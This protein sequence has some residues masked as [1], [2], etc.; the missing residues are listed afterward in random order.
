MRIIVGLAVLLLLIIGVSIF[1]DTRDYYSNDKVALEDINLSDTNSRLGLQTY[2]NLNEDT[3]SDNTNSDENIT[4]V[5]L[6]KDDID[7]SDKSV[8]ETG[9]NM[10]E[11]IQEELDKLDANNTKDYH[12]TTL[13]VKDDNS[14][15]SV[16]TEVNL[17]TDTVIVNKEEKNTTISE[18]NNTISKIKSTNDIDL[19]PFP[20]V[21]NDKSIDVVKDNETISI[22][23]NNESNN[24]T[25]ITNTIK[26]K[27]NSLVIWFKDI[28]PFGKDSEVDTNNSIETTDDINNTITIEKKINDNLSEDINNTDTVDD[29]VTKCV[30]DKC[31]STRTD[32]E[33]TNKVVTKTITKPKDKKVTNK[34]RDYIDIISDPKNKLIIDDILSR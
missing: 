32:K 10:D 3:N 12:V 11:L 33:P 34:K 8:E 2:D 20:M 7:D 22:S 4:P 29:E 23:D 16:T 13:V 28:L 25:S 17:S 21:E 1:K 26:D 15:E 24:S 30:G 5:T 18:V 27:F 9:S 19:E 14:T 31:L 6:V